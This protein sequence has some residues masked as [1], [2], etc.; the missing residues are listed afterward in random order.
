MDTILKAAANTIKEKL[1]KRSIEEL[2]NDVREA[3]NSEEQGSTLVFSIGL[4]VLEEKLDPQ[5]YSE[6]EESLA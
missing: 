5:E 1:S 6:F 3:M 4:D 2:K